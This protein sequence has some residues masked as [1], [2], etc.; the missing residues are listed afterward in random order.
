MLDVLVQVSGFT[1]LWSRSLGLK[2]LYRVHRG[3]VYFAGSAYGSLGSVLW[4]LRPGVA[5]ADAADQFR[6]ASCSSSEGN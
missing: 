3:C 5:A 2:G 6:P 4:R 1:L